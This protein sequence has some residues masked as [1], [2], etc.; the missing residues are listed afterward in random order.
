M[1]FPDG[2]SFKSNLLITSFIQRIEKWKLNLIEIRK[3]IM[4]NYYEIFKMKSI[5]LKFYKI[6][7]Q[8]KFSS[9]IKKSITLE[10]VKF[11]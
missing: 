2:S 1:Y 5:W 8:K 11:M 4:C 10:L 3:I 6:K 7:N 9:M